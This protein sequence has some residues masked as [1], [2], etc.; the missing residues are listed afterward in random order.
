MTVAAATFAIAWGGNEFTPLLVMYRAQEGFSALTV[1]LLLFAYVLG[2]VPALLIGGPLSDRFGR[3]PLMLPAPVLAAVGS[4]ILALG[5]DSAVVLGVGRVFS[6]LA[7]GLAM[8]VGSSW[9]KELSSPPWEDG[10]AGARRAA[11][12]LTAGFGLGAAVAGT[13]AQWGPAPT[14]V[15]YAVNVVMAIVA[16]VL[17]VAAPETRLRTESTGPWWI[18]LA[19]PS[20]AHRRFLRIVVPVAPWVFG[21]GASAYAVLPAL[22]TDRVTAAPIA[23]SALMCLVALGVGFAVQHFGRHVVGRGAGVVL[24]LVLLVFGMALAAWTSAAL[25]VWVALPSAAVL[26]AGYGMALLAGLHEIQRIA[27]PDDLAGLTAVFYSLCYL[28][29]GVPAAMA[30]LSPVVGYPVMFTAGA[31]LAVGCLVFT[32]TGYRR[33]PALS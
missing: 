2:I 9:I 16:A 13:L 27:G 28:G 21:A 3:R 18:D 20:A 11:M 25:S 6:G 31:L 32:V 5:A 24:A 33:V 19:V 30:F 1:D 29:F 10:D 15:P 26:G 8:A 17:L 12:S 7:L 4:L 22:M 14:M 23:F